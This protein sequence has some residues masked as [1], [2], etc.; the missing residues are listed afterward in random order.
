L[1][2]EFAAGGVAHKIFLRVNQGLVLDD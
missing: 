1:L 2:G